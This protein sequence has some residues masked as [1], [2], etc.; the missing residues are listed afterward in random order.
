MV[1][2][3]NPGGN[4]GGTSGGNSGRLK[5][6]RVLVAED[7][8]LTALGLKTLLQVEDATVLGPT[9]TVDGGLDYV[10]GTTIDV[11]LVDMDLRDEFANR[12]IEGLMARKIPFI[13]VTGFQALPNDYEPDAIAVFHKPIDTEKAEKLIELLQTIPRRG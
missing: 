1:P 13:I 10:E 5:D 12:L 9:P 6:L 11:A 8:Y 2:E 4:S 3:S 7:Y